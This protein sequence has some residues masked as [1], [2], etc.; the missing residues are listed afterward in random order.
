VKYEKYTDLKISE[1]L[2]E[3]LFISKGP[4]GDI[5]KVVQ[6]IETGSPGL[7]NLSFG[8]LL[9]DGSVD[10]FSK[11]DNKDRDKIL[12]TVAVVVN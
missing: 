6:F 10:D 4:R 11:T 5:E 1:D 9:P 2:M 12:A 8:N 3:T 7:Y